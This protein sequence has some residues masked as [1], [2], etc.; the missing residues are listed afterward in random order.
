LRRASIER[1]TSLEVGIGCVLLFWAVAGTLLAIPSI[2]ILLWVAR[3]TG[4]APR[5]RRMVVWLALAV[6]ATV[7]TMIAAFAAYWVLC[8]RRGVDPGIGD[9]FQVPLTAGYSLEFIDTV[10]QGFVSP[11]EGSPAAQISGVREV[12][13]S[14]RYIFGSTTDGA[15][16]I[17]TTSAQAERLADREKLVERL[18]QLRAPTVQIVP[19]KDFYFHHRWTKQDLYIPLGVGIPAAVLLVGTFLIAWRRA[20]EPG[21]QP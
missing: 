10:E 9:G 7:V 18:E 13:L 14:G 11:P 2:L 6:P 12:G 17:D 3:R 19:A 21:I 4:G 20:P 8:A 1:E 16:L 5:R 15:F